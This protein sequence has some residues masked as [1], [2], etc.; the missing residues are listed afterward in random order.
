MRTIVSSAVS[1]AVMAI[2]LAAGS[3]ILGAGLC[4]VR[5]EVVY[6]WCFEEVSEA[7]YVS[8]AYGTYDQCMASRHGQSGFCIRNDRFDASTTR[9]SDA[10]SK[11]RKPR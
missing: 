4:P 7:G 5:A 2:G 9:R 3:A 8:C 10:A 1:G 11:P 6:P